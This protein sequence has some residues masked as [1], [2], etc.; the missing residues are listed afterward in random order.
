MR[1]C[2]LLLA[3]APAFTQPVSP[4]AWKEDLDVLARELPA[5]HKNLFFTLKQDQFAREIA[6]IAEGLPRSSDPEI[7]VALTRL[8][9][10]VGNAH[11][12]INALSGAPVYSLRFEQFPDGFY[13]VAAA[14][15][16]REAIGARVIS[17]GGEPTDTVA[18]RLRPLIPM[19]TPLMEKVDA[20]GL[21]RNAWAIGAVKTEFR[22]EKDGRQW[23]LALESATE[24]TMP[25]LEPAQF[26]IPL[27]LSDRA[28]AYWFRYLEDTKT[29]Y[30]QYNRCVSDPS[31]PFSDFTREAMAAADQHAVERVIIDLRH[32]G[33]GN[34][35]VIKP[36]VAALKARP[37]LRQPGRLFVLVSR[38]TFSSAFMAELQLKHE[39]QASIVGEA[40][41]QRPNSYGD[42]RT[43]QL[44]NS[45]LVVRY[46]T[47]YFRLDPHGDPDALLPDIP[48]DLTAQDYFAGRDPVLARVL[49]P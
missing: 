43:F 45:K 20:P 6:S 11:T 37:K 24:T 3:C 36:L 22:L 9:A 12:S 34:S 10:S 39:L 18:K 48:V 44:P 49:H 30:I 42:V 21:L 38:H 14:P 1:Y 2:L 5:R 7:R 29:F 31:K 32:N 17:V 47:K 19:E 33:G 25:K 35:E 28:S 41:A 13:V 40:S 26:P 15:E 46:C 16:N 8:V 27:Y 4:A 23:N